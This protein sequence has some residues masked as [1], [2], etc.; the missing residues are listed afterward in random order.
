MEKKPINMQFSHDHWSHL[1][2]MSL[3]YKCITP[4]LVPLRQNLQEE[5][6]C[7]ER[8]GKLSRK[9]PPTRETT[10]IYSHSIKTRS[11]GSEC[12][13]HLTIVAYLNLHNDFL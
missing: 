10:S 2:Y 6:T 4:V 12:E 11:G 7:A 5:R 3:C 13:L 1:S 8:L 9:M